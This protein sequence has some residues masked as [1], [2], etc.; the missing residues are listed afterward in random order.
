MNVTEA[1]QRIR[2]MQ[3]IYNGNV[4]HDITKVHARFIKGDEREELKKI[5]RT[6]KKPQQ[7]YMDTLTKLNDEDV[8]MILA[9]NVTHLGQSLSVMQNISS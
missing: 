3:V 5:F 9:G 7:Q 4:R 6:G 2:I 8:S 1:Y